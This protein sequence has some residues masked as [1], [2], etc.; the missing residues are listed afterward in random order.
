MGVDVFLDWTQG[1]AQQL[2]ESLSALPLGNIKLKMITNR[3]VKVY[4]DGHPETFCVDNWRC[5]FVA[6]HG[7]GTPISKDDLLRTLRTVH[8]YGFDFI[9]TENLYSFDGKLGYTLGQGE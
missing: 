8:E 4:P 7:P 5:R 1:S 2:G 3:G 9:K 6:E